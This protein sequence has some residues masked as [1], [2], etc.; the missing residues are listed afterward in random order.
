MIC[1]E[2]VAGPWSVVSGQWSVVSGQWSVV[3]GQWSVVSG[4]WS[5]V[6]EE[7][8][9]PGRRPRAFFFYC[10]LTTDHCLRGRVGDRAR[11]LDVDGDDHLVRLGARAE[12]EL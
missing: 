5:V 9:R 3:S 12:R 1:G 6:R 11:A 10:P 8:S 4:Q 7:D 2:V